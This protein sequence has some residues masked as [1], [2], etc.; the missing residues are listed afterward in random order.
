[1][2]KNIL[3]LGAGAW[4]TAIANLL[5]YNS[6]EKV[7][8]WAKEKQVK[9]EINKFKKNSLFLPKVKL[10][11]NLIAI[12]NYQKHYAKYLFLVVPSQ[13]VFKTIKNYLKFIPKDK[14][15]EIKVIIC[16]KG[17]DLKRKKFLSEV[18]EN[19][20]LIKNISILSGPSFAK[21]VALQKPTALTLAGKNLK[22]IQ[23]IRELLHNNFFRVY[24]SKDIIGVQIN[25]ALKNVLAIA[26]G[27]TDGL[28]Y[29]ENARAAIIARGLSEIEKISVAQGGMKNTITG[30]SGFGDILLTCTSVSSRNYYLG[31]LIGQGNSV[32][33]ILK[34]K[35]S[36]TEGVENS[37]AVK[38]LKKDL[39]LDT[40]ILDAVYKII[41]K[42]R[43]LEKTVKDLLSRPLKTE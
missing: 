17:I 22:T 2:E 1:M 27:L 9:E 3:V 4:G 28:G 31:K 15:S 34:K 6:N 12:N 5:A 23:K 25:G 29:G 24:L 21:L 11:T 26:A 10:N 32:A 39:F 30:L 41:I 38:I 43:S 20:V 35:K 14:V 36:I 13:Y 40:P 8:I 16:S 18:I 7:Y 19:H 37:K 42:K 33:E